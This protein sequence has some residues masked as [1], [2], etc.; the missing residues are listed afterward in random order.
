M[1]KFKL[2]TFIGYT[3]L[4][5]SSAFAQDQALLSTYN[6]IRRFDQ[7]VAQTPAQDPLQVHLLR[8]DHYSTEGFEVFSTKK[9]NTNLYGYITNDLGLVS[10]DSGLFTSFG[11]FPIIDRYASISRTVERVED[12]KFGI[13][14][15]ASQLDELKPGDA[16]YFQSTG[17]ITMYLSIGINAIGAG[18]GP[19]LS[20]QGGFTV[21]IE[22]K[23]EN[24]VFVEIRS[25]SIRN[26]SILAGVLGAYGEQ[27]VLKEFTKGVNFLI[28]LSTTKGRNTYENLVMVGRADLAQ[29]SD[30][31][32]TKTGEVVSSATKK[33]QKLA[34][35]TPII[36]FID[37]ATT[38]INHVRNEKRSNIWNQT[39][40]V[41]VFTKGRS[42][43]KRI[44]SIKSETSKI[45]E[46]VENMQTKNID[47][48]T[49]TIR[50][51]KSNFTTS[52][53]V[54]VFRYF[55]RKTGVDFFRN[56]F[57][58]FG[59]TKLGYANVEAKITLSQKS[60][61]KLSRVT[62]GNLSGAS[63][64]KSTRQFV[65]GDNFKNL[66]QIVKRCGG[67]LQLK[68]EGKSI[69]KSF[70]EENFVVTDLCEI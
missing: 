48:A 22:K 15:R 25:I 21:Y 5:L 44:F 31:V 4:S 16:I 41:T 61:V 26:Y 55:Y 53:L 34:I 57:L 68:V 3:L 60:I 32:V 39:S 33:F 65:K 69:T 67:K 58:N 35:A 27:A 12:F 17:G 7:I 13:P 23:P 42:R 59:Q 36:P 63:F 56:V 37:L 54:K 24:K 20:V 66:L 40:D 28:D 8:G 70:V 51:V 18:I 49:L 19:K 2:L 38:K 62:G 30:E 11:L 10:S 6:D 9:I 14:Y 47:S 43:T 50:K 52:R 45:F 1:N 29:E 46:T 64:A